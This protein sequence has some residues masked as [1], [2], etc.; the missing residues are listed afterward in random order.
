MRKANPKGRDGRPPNEAVLMVK[1]LI[2]RDLYQP[3]VPVNNNLLSADRNH[4][5]ALFSYSGILY[6][7]FNTLNRYVLHFFQYSF[8]LSHIL[9]ALLA[10]S[11]LLIC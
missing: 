9:D 11:G 3:E 4:T 6:I 1:T 2:L 8:Q 7:A 10:K 5:F